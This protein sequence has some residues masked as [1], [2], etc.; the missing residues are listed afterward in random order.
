VPSNLGPVIMPLL[1][2]IAASELDGTRV[3]VL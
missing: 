2:T 1:K 3:F